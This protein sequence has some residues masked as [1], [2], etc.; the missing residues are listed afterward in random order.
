MSHLSIVFRPTNLF[1][2]KAADF[3]NIFEAGLK[4]ECEIKLNMIGRMVG[5]LDVLQREASS[6]DNSPPLDCDA[7]LRECCA[8]GLC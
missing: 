5:Q 1:W 6:L 4:V 8:I 2:V 7:L 3:E